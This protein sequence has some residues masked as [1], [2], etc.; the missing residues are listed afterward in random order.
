[1]PC[2]TLCG[3]FLVKSI[4]KNIPKTL[5]MAHKK[6]FEDERLLKKNEGEGL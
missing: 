3:A 5:K 6:L 2:R 4:P 1:M